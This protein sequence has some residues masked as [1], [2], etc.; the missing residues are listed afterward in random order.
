MSRYMRR[1]GTIPESGV[2][3]IPADV[4]EARPGEDGR[5]WSE[6]WKQWFRDRDFARGKTVFAP[7]GS[8]FFTPAGENARAIVHVFERTHAVREWRV[9]HP[10]R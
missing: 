2:L 10:G 1:R 3:R 4:W 5:S 6:R 8:T 7:D 9:A